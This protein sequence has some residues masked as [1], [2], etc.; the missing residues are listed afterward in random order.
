VECAAVS[1]QQD[2]AAEGGRGPGPLP[3]PQ[4]MPGPVPPSPPPSRSAPRGRVPAG[5]VPPDTAV[6]G[7]GAS[8]A[9]LAGG[10]RLQSAWR[11]TADGKTVF[12]L[13]PPL[14]LWWAW[15]VFAV[16]NVVDLA[17][18]T[19]DWFSLQV[20]VAILLVTGVLYACTLRPKIISD[21]GGLTIRNPFR[22]Y[23]VPWG[24]VAGVFLGDSVEIR[25]DRP[26]PKPEKTIYSWALYSSRR[27]RA[28]ADLRAGFGAR[29]E[30]DRHDQRAR[31]RFE[32]PDPSTFGRM[33]AKGKEMASQHPSHVM[34]AELARRSEQARKDGTAPGMVVGQWAW[35][36]IA[37]VIIPLVA[38]IAVILAK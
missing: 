3:P 35:A 4:A 37:A 24:G 2:Q 30:R 33:P 17:I 18:Q 21:P 16:V 14:V 6:S 12:R 23:R 9:G 11:D 13:V 26:G 34:A 22:D 20:V 32:V 19:P 36:P 29:K 7:K 15:T 31:R 38:L 28:K 8:G 27:P 25:C 10:N 5:P 1:S